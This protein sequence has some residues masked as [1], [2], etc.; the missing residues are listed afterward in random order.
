MIF[1][2]F[3]LI[4]CPTKINLW[5]WVY[6]TLAAPCGKSKIFFLLPQEWKMLFCLGFDHDI[7]IFY[8][9]FWNITFLMLTFFMLYLLS[10]QIVMQKVYLLLENL[11]KKRSKYRFWAFISISNSYLF[12]L[13]VLSKP[14]S[15]CR[16][17]F[18][19]PWLNT[20]I[21][22]VVANAVAP[23]SAEINQRFPF[24]VRLLAMSRGELSA[25]IA[26]L[27]SKCL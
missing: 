5:L 14:G 2:H 8:S 6:N 16:N 24:W 1:S 17:S 22:S 23:D 10:S 12:Q 21:Q 25:V 13:L 3:I 9:Y 19:L 15:S 18:A 11:N 7:V 27:M 4:S 26:W 20:G